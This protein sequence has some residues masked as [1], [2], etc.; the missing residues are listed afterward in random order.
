MSGER[1][2]IEPEAYPFTKSR[3]F[4]EC[5][6]LSEGLKAEIAVDEERRR[7]MGKHIEEK[8]KLANPH[9]EEWML[10]DVTRVRV[11]TA[12]CWKKGG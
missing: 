5:G 7:H 12:R 9:Y 2:Q 3:V 11:D 10:K 4:V 1:E 6:E 8:K